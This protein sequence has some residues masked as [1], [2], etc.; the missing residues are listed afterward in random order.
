MPKS[1]APHHI[2]VV[3]GLLATAMQ[4]HSVSSSEPDFERDVAPLLVQRCLECHGAVDSSGGLDLSQHKT[5]IR[6][7][8]SGLAI[9]S[10]DESFLLERLVS[11]EMPP[12]KNGKSQALPP[13]DSNAPRPNEPGAIG[14][15][16][17]RC[18]HWTWG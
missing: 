4:T 14:G 13:N 15:P 17:N 10:K 18:G 1:Y 3:C 5:L 11:G 7:G 8:D 2:F 16:G 9:E 6:G 12:E